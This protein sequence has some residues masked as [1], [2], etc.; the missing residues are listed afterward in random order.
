MSTLFGNA[1]SADDETFIE[2]LPT[3]NSKNPS[4]VV[5]PIIL[6]PVLRS[7]TVSFSQSIIIQKRGAVLLMRA[8][9]AHWLLANPQKSKL[10]ASVV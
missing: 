4:K 5:L 7:V 8:G 1:P 10:R 3:A 6:S 9:I 2:H